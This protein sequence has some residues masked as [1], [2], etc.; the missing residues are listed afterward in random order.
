MPRS[1]DPYD[2]ARFQRRLWT[3]DILAKAGQL[4]AWYDASDLKTITL[5][6][7]NVS[8]WNDKSGNGFNVSQATAGNRPPFIQYPSFGSGPMGNGFGGGQATAASNN[9]FAGG[10]INF[11]TSGTRL[12]FANT[13]GIG[14]GASMTGNGWSSVELF[15]LTSAAGTSQIQWAEADSASTNSVFEDINN[16]ANAGRM[17]LRWVTSG[18][19]AMNTPLSLTATVVNGQTQIMRKQA[20]NAVGQNGVRYGVDPDTNGAN[21]ITAISSN[22]FSIGGCNSST[23]VGQANSVIFELVFIKGTSSRICE[24]CEAYMAWKWGLAQNLAPY[25]KWGRTP[26]EIGWS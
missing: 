17:G 6:S 4:F 26:P 24:I 21:T 13:G 5:V 23:Y 20:S 12:T 10:G 7:G 8:Q 1:L 16:P 15:R 2:N 19:V 9:G 3:P 14:L 22:N 18:G 25:H 11:G